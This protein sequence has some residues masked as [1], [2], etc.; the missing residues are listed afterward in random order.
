MSESIILLGAGRAL[1]FEGKAAEAG[2]YPGMI[3][4]R[5]SATTFSKCNANGTVALPLIAIENNING[6]TKDDVYA[7]GETV[8]ARALVSGMEVQGKLAASADAIVFGDLL[9]PDGDGGLKKSVAA[10]QSG[11]TPFAVV[12]ASV[13]MFK[14]L[15]AVDNSGGA[16]AVF[17]KVQKL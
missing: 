15:E 7:N 5:T 2:I 17:I 11:T 4:E 8:Y 12:N 14:A 3:V 6:K 13:S 16:T 1:Q 9:T 10:S